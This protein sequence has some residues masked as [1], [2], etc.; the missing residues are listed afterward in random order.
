MQPLQN[1]LRKFVKEFGLEGGSALNALRSG[2]S[3]TVG[4][5]IASH[6]YPDTIK[7]GSL[8]ILV[9]T[10]QW[11]HHLSFYKKEISE[12]LKP[13]NVSDI[14][15]RLGRITQSADKEDVQEFS[16]LSGE[17]LRFI[18]NTV[19]GVKDEELR[20][21]VRERIPHGLRKGRNSK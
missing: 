17:D 19:K 16:E 20:Q 18:E 5:T 10:P 14:R 9:D 11:M 7:K 13:Y 6:T 8:T 21:K 2:W 4:P 15:F 12:K 3:R 1:I